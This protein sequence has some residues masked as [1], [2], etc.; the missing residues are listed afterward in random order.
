VTVASAPEG[1][2]HRRRRIVVF[3]VA[4][5]CRL[6]AW[7]PTLTDP[8]R[9]LVPPDS[10][11]YLTLARNLAAGHGLTSDLTPP[12]HP[13]LRRTPVYPAMLAVL[14]RLPGGGPGMAAAAGAC[15]GSLTAVVT[16]GIALELFGSTAA[17]V[18]GLMLAVDS[19]SVAYDVVV[20]TEGLFTL[21]VASSALW[22]VK[23]PSGT[24]NLVCASVLLALAILCRPIAVLLPIVLLPMAVWRAHAVK[25]GVRDYVFIN[26]ICGLAILAWVMRNVLVA[27]VVTFSS[28]GAVNLYFHRAAAVEARIEG[29]DVEGLRDEWQQRFDADN[30]SASEETKLGQLVR[31]GWD[32]VSQHPGIYLRAYADGLVRMAGPDQEALGQLA[33]TGRHTPV[34]RWMVWMSAVQLVATYAGALFGIA[35][36]VRGGAWRRAAVVPLTFIGYFLITAGP[37]VYPRFRVPVMPFLVVLSG[38]GLEAASVRRLAARETSLVTAK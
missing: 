6:A 21:L 38:V 12:Y 19:S 2:I 20:L 30:G 11:E 24:G 27:G 35:C 16:Y 34:V 33:G 31:Q 5:V 18:A 4:L 28:I 9:L 36:S 32:M 7:A 1:R 25:P 13:D 22:F 3:A 10:N 23:R 29:R 17:I 15:F 14:F 37:E 26:V 8:S